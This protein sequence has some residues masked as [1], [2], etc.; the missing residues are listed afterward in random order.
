MAQKLDINHSLGNEITWLVHHKGKKTHQ[1][2][3]KESVCQ[4]VH[5]ISTQKAVSSA[6]QIQQ[7]LLTAKSSA[8]KGVPV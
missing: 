4:S 1:N 7:T 3:K 8:I 5:P 6:P 2:W